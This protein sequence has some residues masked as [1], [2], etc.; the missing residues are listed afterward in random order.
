MTQ[1]DALQE[2][3]AMWSAGLAGV[4]LVADAA[5]DLLASG[6]DSPHL[7]DLAGRSKDEQWFEIESLIR[8]TFEELS[9]PYPEP[10]VE[11]T[12]LLALLF[13]CREFL[14]GRRTPRELTQFA[15]RVIGHE[16]AEIAQ[17]LVMLDDEFDGELAERK[18]QQ[19]CEGRA[20]A[21]VQHMRG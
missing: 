6:Q 7:R 21:F 16:G 17:D 5:T 10:D 3:T 4:G 1:F 11:S 13:V 14:N 19:E 9:A 12:R 15:H 18:W 2:A 20:R 8:S